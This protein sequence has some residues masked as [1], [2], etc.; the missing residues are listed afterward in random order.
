MNG[1][2]RNGKY[3]KQIQWYR[4]LRTSTV[5]NNYTFLYL[6]DLVH[7]QRITIEILQVI[8]N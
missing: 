8:L 3:L 2:S 5:L 4:A 7:E 1:V 6:Y